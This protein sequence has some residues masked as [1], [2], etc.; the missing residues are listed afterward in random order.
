KEESR[1]QKEHSREQHLEGREVCELLRPVPPLHA[2]RVRVHPESLAEGGSEP[3]RLDESAHHGLDF[4]DAGAFSNGAERLGTRTSGAHFEMHPHEVHVQW[5]VSS[6]GLLGHAGDGGVESHAGLHT[7]HQQVED[8]RERVDY[9][10]LTDLDAVAEPEV[11]Q[12]ETD[13]GED[14]RDGQELREGDDPQE[15]E[16]AVDKI[17]GPE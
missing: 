6:L 2:S 1:H 4:E 9:L 10:S 13:P 12:E 14:K 8:V 17:G 11:G 5:P 15:Y 16:A 3:F 7:N